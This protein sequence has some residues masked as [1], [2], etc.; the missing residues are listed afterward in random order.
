MVNGSVLFYY[1]TKFIKTILINYCGQIEK[2]KIV[3]LTGNIN[4][5]SGCG[6]VV[7]TVEFAESI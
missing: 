5:K 4:Q 6:A 7:Y 1:K 3:I 2:N